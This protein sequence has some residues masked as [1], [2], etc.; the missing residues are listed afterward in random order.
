MPRPQKNGLA[1]IGR[2][3]HMPTQQ[4][5]G[6]RARQNKKIRQ[7]GGAL[8]AAGLHSL[9]EQAEALALPRSTTWTLRRAKHYGSG[10]SAVIVAR[11]LSAPDLPRP[12]RTKILEYV[13]QK[14]AGQYGDTEWKLRRFER[15]LAL[16]GIV[17]K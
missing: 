4:S 13:T 15:R 7:I 14:M 5:R 1:R 17:Y 16:Y 11:M 12:V 3:P 10:L 9:D 8:A 2:E 6:G